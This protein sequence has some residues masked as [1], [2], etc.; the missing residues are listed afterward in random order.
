[1]K[2]PPKEGLSPTGGRSPVGGRREEPMKDKLT[3]LIRIDEVTWL[4]LRSKALPF[5]SRGKALRRILGIDEQ[6]KKEKQK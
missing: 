3:H 6:T 5:E 2:P 1:M 4:W